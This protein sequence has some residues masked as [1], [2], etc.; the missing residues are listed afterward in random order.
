[1]QYGPLVNTKLVELYIFRVFCN[2]CFVVEFDKELPGT[3]QTVE[4]PMT[5]EAFIPTTENDEENITE[6]D[7]STR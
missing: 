3:E 2:I 7:L 6:S 4:L 5:T 1:M